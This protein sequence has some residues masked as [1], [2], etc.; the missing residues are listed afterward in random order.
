[1]KRGKRGKK[2]GKGKRKGK[3]KGRERLKDDSLRKVRRTNARTDTQVILYSV[4]CYA[5][6]WTDNYQLCYEHDRHPKIMTKRL[7]SNVCKLTI[8]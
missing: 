3:E 2:K 7:Q 8:T 6:H 5:L 4:Q 1:M